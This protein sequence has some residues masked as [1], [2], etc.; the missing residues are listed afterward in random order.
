MN[1]GKRLG[2][3]QGQDSNVNVEQTTSYSMSELRLSI[4]SIGGPRCKK[5]P[6][7]SLMD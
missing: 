5:M 2:A 3:V 1:R 6:T 4:L 7:Y